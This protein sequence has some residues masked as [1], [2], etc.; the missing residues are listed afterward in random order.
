[1]GRN[2]QAQP[3]SLVGV[4]AARTA[5]SLTR[6][7]AQWLPPSAYALCRFGA[8]CTATK[9]RWGLVDEAEQDQ[10]YEIAAG[11]RDSEVEFTPAP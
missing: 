10:L 5:A 7:R 1:M 4:T 6:I 9:L 2:D 11:C 3:A 8:E